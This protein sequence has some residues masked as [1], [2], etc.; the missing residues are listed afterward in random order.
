MCHQK[1]PFY[2]VCFGEEMSEQYTYKLTPSPKLPNISS[3]RKIG[4]AL[5]D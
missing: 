3:Y 5:S 1:H 4:L 2:H